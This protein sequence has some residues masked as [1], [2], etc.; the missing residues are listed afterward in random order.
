M[1]KPSALTAAT[2]QV[3]VLETLH[4]GGK[5]LLMKADQPDRT[6]EVDASGAF[7]CA[8]KARPMSEAE[9]Y[10]FDRLGY[11]VFRDFLTTEEVV[12][13]R[14][15]TEKLEAHANAML[16]PDTSGQPQLPHK[17]SPWGRT[18]YHYNP[19]LGYHVGPTSRAAS[20]PPILSLCIGF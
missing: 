7:L 5:P 13:L 6:T 14:V 3:E 9:K 12:S 11:L 16:A 19:E 17:L 10:E 18:R 8:G 15:A 4:A 2:T 20:W 1:G